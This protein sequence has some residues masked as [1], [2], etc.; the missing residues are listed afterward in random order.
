MVAFTRWAANRP[1]IVTVG[2]AGSWALGAERPSSDV[3]LIVLTAEWQADGPPVLLGG[4][5]PAA[6]ERAGRRAAG[7]LGTGEPRP[8]TSTGCGAPPGMPPSGPAATRG[9]CAGRSGSTSPP[10]RAWTIWPGSAGSSAQGV[11]GAFV[12]LIGKVG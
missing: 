1:D 5:T 7:W 10:R 2:L 11:D 4:F 3:D 9:R 6:A 8:G 12:D